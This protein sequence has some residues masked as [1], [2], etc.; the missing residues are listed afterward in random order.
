MKISIHCPPNPSFCA[1]VIKE[2]ARWSFDQRAAYRASKI[3]VSP[4][5][6]RLNLAGTA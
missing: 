5:M 2:K 1:V 4:Q 6:G 3:F